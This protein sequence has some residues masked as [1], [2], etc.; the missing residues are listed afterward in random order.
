MDGAVVV[1][2]FDVIE[3][4]LFAHRRGQLDQL[5]ANAHFL[6]ARDLV[7]DVGL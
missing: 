7:A 5:G 3:Q 1:Q 6:A 2:P 4:F